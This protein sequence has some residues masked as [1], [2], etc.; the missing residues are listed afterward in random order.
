MA[1]ACDICGKLYNIE[2]RSVKFYSFSTRTSVLFFI[3]R[4][5]AGRKLLEAFDICPEC[6]DKVYKYIRTMNSEVEMPE[7]IPSGHSS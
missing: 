2:D 3:R 7:Y 4:D 5:G 6:A 1:T